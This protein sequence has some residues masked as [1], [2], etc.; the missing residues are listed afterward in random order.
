MQP[1]VGFVDGVLPYFDQYALSHRVWAPDSTS[2]VLPLV[3]ATGQT[4]VDVVPADGSDPRPIADG[5]A[6]FWSP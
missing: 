6:A 3:D 2:M 5:D 1:A 4:H